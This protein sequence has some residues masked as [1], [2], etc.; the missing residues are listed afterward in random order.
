MDTNSSVSYWNGSFRSQRDDKHAHATHQRER[1][2]AD[3][4]IRVDL[5]QQSSSHSLRMAR[6]WQQTYHA[7]LELQVPLLAANGFLPVGTRYGEPRT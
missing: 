1:F 5:Q 4:A 2:D 3:E 6:S 7:L